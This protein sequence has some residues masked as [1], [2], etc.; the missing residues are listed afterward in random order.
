MKFCAIL[1]T[2]SGEHPGSGVGRMSAGSLRHFPNTASEG[3]DPSAAC[4]V[5]CKDS[6]THGNLLAQSF[7]TV[8]AAKAVLRVL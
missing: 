7:S 4:G 3:A 2:A 8:D 5:E 6:I 1:E